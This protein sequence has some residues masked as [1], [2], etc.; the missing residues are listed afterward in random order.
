MPDQATHYECPVCRSPSCEVFGYIVRAD[1]KAS[2]PLYSCSICT[3][4]FLDPLALTRAYADRPRRSARPAPG[5]T[6]YKEW[7]LINQ[8]RKDRR[9]DGD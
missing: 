9:T 1:G 5:P 3:N 2:L 4:I 7:S 8:N 6:S